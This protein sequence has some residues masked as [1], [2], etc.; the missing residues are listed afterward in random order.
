MTYLD[1]LV[2]SKQ[3]GSLSTSVYRKPTH[4]DFYLEWD[5]HHTIS[6]KYSVVGSLH[7]RAKTACSSPQ[8]LQQEEKYLHKILIK[9]KYLA[10]ALNR[11]K[12]K[13]QA[14]TKNNNRRGTNNSGNNTNNNQNP[15][16]VV[17]YSKGLSESLKKACSKHEVQVYFKEGMI[18]GTSLWLERTKIPSLKRVESYTDIN[19]AGWRVMKS[20]LVNLPRTFGERFREYQKSLSPIYD[21]SNSTVHTVTIENVSIVGREDQN[22]LEPSEKHYT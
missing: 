1:I 11:V 10:W 16:I 6:S 19:V 2:T 15:Y 5:S 7:H 14:P 13:T 20:T 4:T 3:D 12:F 8:L 9:C 17:P 22:L 21:H 18:S